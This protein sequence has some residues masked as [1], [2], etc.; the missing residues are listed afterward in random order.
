MQWSY[1]WVI[2]LHVTESSLDH[3]LTQS[4]SVVNSVME[5]VACLSCGQ[6]LMASLGNNLD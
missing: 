2:Y 4:L 3:F 5:C 1:L 6:L